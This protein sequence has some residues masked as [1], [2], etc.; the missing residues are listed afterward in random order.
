MGFRKIE[1]KEP[2]ILFQYE[3]R[4]WIAFSGTT[5]PPA[6]KKVSFWRMLRA[7]GQSFNFA[8]RGPPSDTAR[9]RWSRV[10]SRSDCIVGYWYEGARVSE[11]P[12]T[13]LQDGVEWVRIHSMET[14]PPELAGVNGFEW[15]TIS[16]AGRRDVRTNP[17][18]SKNLYWGTGWQYAGYRILTSVEAGKTSDAA[19]RPEKA[20]PV[21]T[22]DEANAAMIKADGE[23]E[24]SLQRFDRLVKEMV[25]NGNIFAPPKRTVHPLF[26]V[27]PTTTTGHVLW[28]AEHQGG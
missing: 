6:L 25:G 21:I 18:D 3:G 5:C 1:D 13:F 9:N 7:D 16:I 20:K 11:Q 14:M 10:R 12:K 17:P 15:E 27:T 19:S 23:P 24:T 28:G 4:D 22:E 26:R 2:G 8:D